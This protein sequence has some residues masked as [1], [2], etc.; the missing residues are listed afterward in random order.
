[1]R[2]DDDDCHFCKVFFRK[3]ANGFH[4]LSLAFQIFFFRDL[5]RKMC[6]RSH[7]TDQVLVFGSYN[8]YIQ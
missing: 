3:V 8:I 1:V 4:H 5:K 2:H 6:I 7:R